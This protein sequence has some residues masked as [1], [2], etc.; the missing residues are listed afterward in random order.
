[1]DNNPLPQYLMQWHDYWIRSGY[2]IVFFVLQKVQDELNFIKIAVRVPFAVRLIEPW[3][4]FL[5]GCL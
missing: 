3:R 1:M 5:R 4:L 2:F